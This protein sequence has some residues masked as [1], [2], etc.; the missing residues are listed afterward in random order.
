MDIVS[1]DVRSRMMAG[2]RSKDTSPE[3]KVR[4]LLH[5]LGFRYRL[6]LRELPGKPDMVL[7]RHQVCIFVHGCFWHR[8]PGC[9]YS[10][11]P[12]TREDFWHSKFHQNVERDIR[13]RNELL[14]RGWRVIEIWECG[15]RTPKPDIDW[16]REVIL[17]CNQKYVSWPRAVSL[18]SHDIQNDSSDDQNQD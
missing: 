7:P 8:H 11:I 12:K 10:T 9:K 6:H 1:K 16:L 3:L 13:N 5:R 17:D 4:K 15:L 18:G 2:I 14:Q